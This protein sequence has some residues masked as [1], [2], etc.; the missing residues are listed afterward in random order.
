M[1]VFNQVAISYRRNNFPLTSG[2]LSGILEFPTKQGVAVAFILP[3][4][5]TRAV[6]LFSAIKPRLLAC[7]FDIGGKLRPGFREG[8]AALLR[9]GSVVFRLFLF[10]PPKLSRWLMDI[11]KFRV[12]RQRINSLLAGVEQSILEDQRL[13]SLLYGMKDSGR[14]CPAWEDFRVFRKWARQ[15]GIQRK[16]ARLVL[17]DKVAGYSPENCII[18]ANAKD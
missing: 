12:V 6:F 16:G 4:R 13:E 17:L 3:H 8:P 5:I 10:K 7:V 9:P 1:A 2:R 15:N 11:Q 18:T 14:M